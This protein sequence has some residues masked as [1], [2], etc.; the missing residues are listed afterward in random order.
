MLARAACLV[1]V[2]AFGASGSADWPVLRGDPAHRGYIEGELRGPFRIAWVRHFEAER[3]G[4]AVEPIVARGRV[5]IGTHSGNLWALDAASGRPVW[6]FA[7]G[8]PILHSPAV[9]GEAVVVASTRGLFVLDLATGR[10]L[11]QAW[12]RGGYSAAPVVAGQRVFIGS[13][14]GTFEAFDLGLKWLWKADLGVPIRQTA[15]VAN[16][17][18]F[19]VAEDLRLRC[20]DASSGKVLW[21][22][23][24]LVGQTARD[25]YPVVAK[26]NGRSL[27][28]VRTNPVVRMSDL[29]GLDRRMLC[30]NAGLKDAGWR[31]I[32]AWSR[33]QRA[34]GT[35][36]LLAREGDAIR[37]HIERHRESR[38]FFA[39]DAETGKPLP[40]A[41]VLWCGGCQ[42][43]GTPPNVLP[44]G[45]LLVFYRSAYGNWNHGV[46][47]LVALGILDPATNTIEQLRH[48]HGMRPPWNTFWGTAD[49][50]QN[51]LVVGRTILVIHQ[52]TLSTFDLRTRRL[53]TVAGKRDTWGGFR[54]LPWARNEWHGPGRGSVAVVGDSIFWQTGSRV[55]C[56]RA[57]ERGQPAPDIAIAASD[58]PASAIASPPPPA[59]ADLV[60]ALRSEVAEML[61]KD[62]APLYV[63]PGLA[64]REFLFDDSGEFFEALALAF[65]HLDEALKAKAREALRRQWERHPPFSPSAWYSLERGARREFFPWVPP[66]VLKRLQRPALHHP[67]GNLYAVWLCASRCGEWDRVVAAWPRLKRCFEDFVRSGWKL[68]PERGDLY[69]NRYLASLLAFAAIAA[70]VGD[71]E[72]GARAR[73]LAR[74]T[75]ERLVAWWKAWAARNPLRVFRDIKEWDRF[76]GRG[77]GALFYRIASHKARVAQFHQMTPEVASAL[78]KRAPGAVA[79]LWAA[80]EAL[81]P[82]WDLAGEERQVHYGENFLDPPDFALD[83]FRAAAWL[84]GLSGRD[85]AARVDIPFCRADLSHIAKLA[86]ALDRF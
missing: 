37:R 11:A 61:A 23:E 38:T 40:W 79:R 15:A 34:L 7:A 55:I 66:R 70:R 75:T 44:D 78:R 63:E 80:F 64:G 22:S 16:G 68:D 83:A 20:F 4:S 51:F 45:R 77:D 31:T 48:T 82:T 60:A 36:D 71:T 59:R 6:R 72:S 76:I 56:I 39:F 21:A 14:G 69:A 33:D 42:G 47:P 18:V 58:V 5:F 27:V 3:I 32:E 84:G 1:T 65:P 19:V 57:G 49:E 29:I 30:Q 54:N 9:A 50:S 53:A 17:R 35:P 67:F 46:A 52:G 62:W 12:R 73:A 2:L 8:S 26:R 85:L 13:R 43:V 86:I 41:P 24:P 25:Y 74:D 81:C 28:I 10:L